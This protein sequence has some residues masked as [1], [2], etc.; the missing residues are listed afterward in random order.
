MT[1]QEH[2]LIIAAEECVEVAQRLTK[3]LRFGLDEVQPNATDGIHPPTNPDGLTNRERVMREYY[4]L[5][6]V[7][8]MAGFDAWDVSDRA[9]RC[10]EAKVEKVERFLRYSATCG[11]LTS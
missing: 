5:R 8:G 2:L 10:E 6:A 9:R 3:A 4:D 7:L 1:R 11:T